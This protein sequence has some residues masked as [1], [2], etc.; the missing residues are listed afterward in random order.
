M[1]TARH[2]TEQIRFLGDDLRDVMVAMTITFNQAAGV[3]VGDLGSE[4]LAAEIERFRDD[5]RMGEGRI[6]DGLL[7]AVS[8]LRHAAD[9]YE[10]IEASVIGATGQQR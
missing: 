2:D 3:H 4:H 8:F 10:A 9:V 7:D 5:W 1:V 6:A